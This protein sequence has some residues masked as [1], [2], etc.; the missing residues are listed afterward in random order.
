MGRVLYVF[1][2]FEKY[3]DN[4]FEISKS[5]WILRKQEGFLQQKSSYIK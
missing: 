1:V 3:F 5:A 2:F 4:F